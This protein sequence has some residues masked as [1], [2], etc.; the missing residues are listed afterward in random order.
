MFVDRKRSRE[1]PCR[2]AERVANRHGLLFLPPIR[3]S[4]KVEFIYMSV[5]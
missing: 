3:L 1:S 4:R 2:Y 5:K